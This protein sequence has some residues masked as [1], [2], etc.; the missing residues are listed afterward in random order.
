MNQEYMECGFEG[1]E[2]VGWMKRQMVQPLFSMLEELPVGVDRDVHMLPCHQVL[3][4]WQTGQ[5]AVQV[6]VE[7][8]SPGQCPSSVPGEHLSQK[9]KER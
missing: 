3:D 9:H 1:V 8:R 7:G 6:E 4:L 2:G 5:L